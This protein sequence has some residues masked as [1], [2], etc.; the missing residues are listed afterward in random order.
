M[1]N[2]HALNLTNRKHSLA[3]IGDASLSEGSPHSIRITMA[4]PAAGDQQET[5][6]E[7]LSVFFLTD[8]VIQC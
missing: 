1:S 7:T 5:S 6:L 3:Q 2:I 8:L 4:K